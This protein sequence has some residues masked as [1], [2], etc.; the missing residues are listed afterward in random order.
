MEG[1]GGEG[2]GVVGYTLTQPVKSPLI[3][4]SPE[5]DL[6]TDSGARY[7]RIGC[8]TLPMCAIPPR[9]EAYLPIE[10]DKW[11]RGVGAMRASWAAIT[12]ETNM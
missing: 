9:S 12:V 10:D 1:K 5:M 6:V 11:D 8:P 3:R 7:I 2:S 4:C